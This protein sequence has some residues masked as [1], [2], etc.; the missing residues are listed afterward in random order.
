MRIRRLAL[1]LMLPALSGCGLFDAPVLPDDVVKT[2]D[3]AIRMARADCS[4][5]PNE[6][7]DWGASR[8]GDIWNVW[9]SHRQ[10]SVSVQIRKSD[11]AFEDCQVH[12][13]PN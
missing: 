8:D 13:V 11:G 10:S 9:W 2:D 5:G 12:L 4:P 6:R 7:D 3:D 1:V